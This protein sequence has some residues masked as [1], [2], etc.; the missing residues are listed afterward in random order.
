M[1]SQFRL[2]FGYGI[3]AERVEC[4]KDVVMIGL[5]SHDAIESSL[6]TVSVWL[7]N[8]WLI[9]E[10]VCTY[11]ERVHPLTPFR[12]RTFVVSKVGGFQRPASAVGEC[13]ESQIE[14]KGLEVVAEVIGRVHQ[15]GERH[16]AKIEVDIV[17]KD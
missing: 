14:I 5:R 1:S 7:I 11:Q 3:G 16:I 4:G 12:C 15:A 2:T 13:N 6:V 8:V 10:W 17:G 9:I